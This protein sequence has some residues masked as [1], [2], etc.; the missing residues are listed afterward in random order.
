M[1]DYSCGVDVERP[2]R[3]AFAMEQHVGHRTYYQ[4]LRAAMELGGQVEARWVEITYGQSGGLWERL[5]VPAQLRSALRG[6]AQA[7]RALVDRSLDAAFFNTQVP[8]VLAEPLTRRRP[9]VITTDITPIQY[10]RMAHSYGHQADRGGLVALLKH[11]AS[12]GTLRRAAR[13]LAWSKWVRQ[14]LVDDYGLHESRV[15]VLPPGVD[16]DV[17]H[18]VFRDPERPVRVLFVGGDLRRKGGLALLEAWRWL[19]SESDLAGRP[20]TH[21]EL[22]LVT[23][24]DVPGECDDW[25]VRV[26][27]GLKPN[28]AELVAL[29]QRCDLFVLPSDAEAF[30]I[31]AVEASAVGLPVV[32]TDVGGLADVVVDGETG[33]LIQAGDLRA[34]QDRLRRLIADA[35]LRERMGQAARMRALEHFDCAVNAGRIA[36]ILRDVVHYPA[37]DF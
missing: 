22:H 35:A 21:M 11:R 27:R 4:N 17:W 16:T 10:D 25:G 30:G 9:Y 13:V 3:V 7:R 29:F 20:P 32:A 28:S 24:S 15:C 34:L 14:S 31:A 37:L 36:Q 2:L 18:P 1:I 33:Y 23:R 26:H 6:R 5:P 19:R 8:A 12:A